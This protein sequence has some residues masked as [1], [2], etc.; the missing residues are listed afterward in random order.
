VT[1]LPADGSIFV[2][3]AVTKA[4]KKTAIPAAMIVSGAAAPAVT[5]IT[6]NAK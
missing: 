6:P 3:S 2:N 1:K 5:A 4:R